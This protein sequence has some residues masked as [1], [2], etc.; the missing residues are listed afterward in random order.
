MA[1]T[2]RITG[3]TFRG[4]VAASDAAPIAAVSI[5]ASMPDSIEAA[6]TAGGF[7]A[8]STPASMAV[9]SMA[10]ASMVAVY[11]AAVFMAAEG[12]ADN[13]EAN[14]S[15]ER[16]SISVIRDPFDHRTILQRQ[17]PHDFTASA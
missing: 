16:F 11:M 14:R 2:I 8:V 1:T 15:L 17:P 4:A 13:P 5:A 7:M 10:A 3:T 12:I 6:S 9:A